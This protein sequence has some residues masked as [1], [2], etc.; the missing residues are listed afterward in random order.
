MVET[1]VLFNPSSGRGRSM[2]NRR[3]IK[4]SLRRKNIDFDWLTSENESHLRGLARDA[5]RNFSNLVVVGGDTTFQI[6]ASEILAG[7]EDPALGLLGA[8]SNNDVVHGLGDLGLQTLHDA[9]Q[10]RRTRRMD[11]GRIDIPGKERPVIF[12]GALSLGLGVHVNRHVAEFW[13]R[14]PLISRGGNLPQL[15]AGIWGVRCFFRERSVPAR[16]RLKGAGREEEVDFSLLVFANVPS[17][18]GGLRLAPEVTPF[19]GRLDC[20]A[21]KSDSFS[22]TVGV[23]MRV[24]R[25][26]HLRHPDVSLQTGRSFHVSSPVPLDIQYDGEILPGVDDFQVSAWPGALRVLC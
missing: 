6:V 25:G 17:Y 14:H 3:R 23:A 16:I 13:K 19:N 7:K 21:V 10:A 11:V 8:G 12:L 15:L 18:A 22:G 20:C 9:I 4:D 1:A 26:R 5:A 2:R 24:L